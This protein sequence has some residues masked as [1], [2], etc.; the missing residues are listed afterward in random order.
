MLEL[1][2][3]D[4]FD[5]VFCLPAAWLVGLS[6]TADDVSNDAEVEDGRGGR[7][8]IAQVSPL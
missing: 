1:E 6:V 4:Q 5:D 8:L 7:T 2:L 3:S